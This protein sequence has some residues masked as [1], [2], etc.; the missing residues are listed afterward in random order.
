MQS[1]MDNISEQI[2]KTQSVDNISYSEENQYT[3]SMLHA[4]GGRCP[5][6]SSCR[7]RRITG[8]AQSAYKCIHYMSSIPISHFSANAKPTG[9]ASCFRWGSVFIIIT[10]CLLITFPNGYSV[11][12]SVLDRLLIYSFRAV[13]L[14]SVFVIGF[15]S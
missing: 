15:F 14:S 1:S 2:C 11:A 3:A 9:K 5:A 8:I 6:K 4:C 13:I 12:L 10:F 7:H